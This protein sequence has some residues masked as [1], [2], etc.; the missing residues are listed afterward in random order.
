MGKILRGSFQAPWFLS[1]PHLQ[2]CLGILGSSRIHAPVF[3]EELQL[4]DG[5]FVDLAWLGNQAEG[6]IALLIP[7]LEGNLHAHYIASL[8]EPLLAEAW[9]V[10]V[11]HFR[12][13]SGRSNMLPRGYSASDSDD[14]HMVLA[15]L[16]MQNPGVSMVGIGFSLGASI[17]LKMLAEMSQP[18]FLNH[19]MSAAVGVSVPYDLAKTLS[20]MPRFYQHRLLKTMK[21]KVKKKI[22][23]GFELPITLKELSKIDTICEFDE[24]ITAPLHEFKSLADY[25][26]CSSCGSTLHQITREVL[27][28]HAEDDPLVPQ[29]CIPTEAALG[30]RMN[31]ELSQQGGHLGFLAGHFPMGWR[32]WLVPRI[33][34]FIR[35]YR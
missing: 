20:E 24:K 19:Y 25:Y 27:L 13:C 16:R 33:L 2:T 32:H 4:P 31:L 14:L 34:E 22:K 17:L 18:P 12:S 8:V 15:S 9:R 10:V 1:N 29:S 6:P 35:A 21:A 23:S 30:E 7:G 26:Q 28:I 11:M 3:W 5:D